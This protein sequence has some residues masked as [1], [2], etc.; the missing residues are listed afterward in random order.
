MNTNNTIT[1]ENDNENK[2]QNHEEDKTFKRSALGSLV[3][4][5]FFGIGAIYFQVKQDN[6][7]QPNPPKGYANIKLIQ[8]EL[9]NSKKNVY[10][11]RQNCAKYDSLIKF[12]PYL[13]EKSIYTIWQNKYDSLNSFTQQKEKNISELENTISELETPEIKKYYGQIKQYEQEK[14]LLNDL[15][16]GSGWG[17]L[18]F[19]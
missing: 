10:Q 11:L 5:I 15:I 3:L 19:F 4:G 16:T 14:D 2:G 1:E 18:M 7:P 13:K 6:L 17:T 12:N 8:S 9:E